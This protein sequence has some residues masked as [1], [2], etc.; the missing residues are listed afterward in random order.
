MKTNASTGLGT[1]IRQRSLRAHLPQAW[2]EIPQNRISENVHYLLLK[3][4]DSLKKPYPVFTREQ[5]IL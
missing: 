2:S 3:Q 1:K 5:R 4:A